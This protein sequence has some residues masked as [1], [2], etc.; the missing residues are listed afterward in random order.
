MDH[1]AYHINLST[2]KLFHFN[3]MWFE[4]KIKLSGDRPLRA[5]E[6]EDEDNGDQRNQV[7]GANGLHH[8]HEESGERTTDE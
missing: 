5:L 8:R 1:Q 2:T 4:E 7:S 3:G 6:E